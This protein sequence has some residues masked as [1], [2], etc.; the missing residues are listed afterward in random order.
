MNANDNCLKAPSPAALQK[1]INICY[2]YIPNNP[3]TF[4]SVIS[5]L[6]LIDY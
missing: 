1:L 4:S 2:D 3:S 5:T 6:N